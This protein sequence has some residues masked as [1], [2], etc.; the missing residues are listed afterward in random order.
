LSDVPDGEPVVALV[1]CYAGPLENGERA[2]APLRRFGPPLVDTFDR[3]PYTAMQALMGAAFPEGRLNLLVVSLTSTITDETI[4]AITDAAA[5]VPSPHSAIV[6]A[7]CHGAY[8]RVA[9]V[10]TAYP[11]R[12]LQYDL[13][14]LSSS[15][16]P[17]DTGRNVRWTRECFDALQ[18]HLDHGVYVNDLG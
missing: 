10:D 6:F 2:L 9:D 7:D 18:P 17:S 5:R 3:L 1:A 14:I 12:H 15:A 16:N 4:E 8:G 13:V 11:H